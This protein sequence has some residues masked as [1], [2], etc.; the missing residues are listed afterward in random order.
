MDADAIVIGSGQAGVPLAA[1]LAGA[2]KRTILVERSRLGGTCVNY[3]CTPTK[4]MVASARAAHVA[5]TAGRLGVQAGSVRID[6]PAIVARKDAIVRRWQDGVRKRISGAGERLQLVEG[7]ARF[8]SANEIEVGSQRYRAGLIVIDVGVRP[9]VPEV[10]GL[11]G[12]P[13]LDNRRVMELSAVPRHLVVLG[14]GYI[15]CEFAQMFRRFGS[16]VTIVESMDRLMSHED[17]E[18]SAAL[19]GVFE[20]EGIEL[21]LGAKAASVSGTADDLRVRLDSGGDV[22][23]S[24]LLVALG[25]RPNTDD[26][27]CDAAGI[28]RDPRGYIPVDDHYKTS[29]EGVY[30]VGD[31]TPGPQFT[32]ASWDDHRLLFD[33]LMGRPGRKRSERLIPITAFTDPQ[34]AR[35]GLTEEG[36]KKAGV[37]YEAATMPFGN[38]ARAVEL[39]ETAG[40]M[41]VLID[42][43]TER[44]LGAS[45]VGAEAGELIHVFVGL[46]SA[47][48]S[49]RALVDA[50]CVHPT[51]A[52]G[53][54][55]LVMKLKRYALR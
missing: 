30:A 7:H 25:R 10:E 50:E 38:I 17:P 44:I 53:L 48:A 22:T 6:F 4:T 18:S 41:K 37:A 47:G 8:V 46:V 32:H 1:R 3:G 26:L 20:S 14:G 13:W 33:H 49:A 16:D 15:G 45:I 35:V 28:A 52:E 21:A 43:R 36:A 5:R 24:H 29:A 39:D 31:V 19:R 2:G 55:T 42:P 12:L 11:G 9:A 40:T 23:G 51:F 27:G 34:V 54:Q